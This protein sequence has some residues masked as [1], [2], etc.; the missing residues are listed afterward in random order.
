MYAMEQATGES[1]RGKQGAQ[2]AT[3][4]SLPEQ[5]MASP[6][7]RR[8]KAAIFVEP[9][10]TAASLRSSKEYVR[11]EPGLNECNAALGSSSSGRF[12]GAR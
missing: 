3:A 8:A 5:R 4:E 10:D 9:P 11:S 12:E 7:V 6:S 1:L 2:P